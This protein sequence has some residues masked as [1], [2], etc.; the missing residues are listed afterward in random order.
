MDYETF[1]SLAAAQEHIDSMLGWD[2]IPEQLFIADD[3]NSDDD[4]NV[5]AVLCDGALHLRMDG[6]VR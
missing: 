2:A 3:P 1:K 5:W 4:G 6:F